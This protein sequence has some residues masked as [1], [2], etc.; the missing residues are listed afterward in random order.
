MLLAA[1]GAPVMKP[2]GQ[3]MH[4]DTLWARGKGLYVPVGQAMHDAA[5]G[6][7]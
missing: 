1:P 5:S 3:G 7:E 6:D 4:Q 2:D